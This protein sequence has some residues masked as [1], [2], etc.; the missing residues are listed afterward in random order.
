[1]ISPVTVTGFPGSG[2]PST[3]APTVVAVQDCGGFS[4]N[5]PM[6]LSQPPSG[7]IWGWRVPPDLV[8]VFLP[9]DFLSSAA[10]RVKDRR[11]TV[12]AAKSVFS[13]IVLLD[14]RIQKKQGR[15]ILHGKR[16]ERE[17]CCGSVCRITTA[18]P[19]LPVQQGET[20]SDIV[21]RRRF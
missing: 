11:A 15:I 8:A 1:M 20:F 18:V 4:P 2:L 12:R 5:G 10:V 3:P 13:D 6:A 21:A 14:S 16:G 19:P 17:M 9:S 7:V